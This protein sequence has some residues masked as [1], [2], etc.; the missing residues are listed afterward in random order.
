M[1]KLIIFSAATSLVFLASCIGPTAVRTERIDYSEAIAATGRQ[2]ILL[3]FVRVYCHEQPQFTDI[4]QV[5][6]AS[7]VSGSVGA[8]FNIPQALSTLGGSTGY[9][10]HDYAPMFSLEP[11]MIRQPLHILHSWETLLLLKS[12]GRSM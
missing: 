4:T 9:A 3:N 5:N 1:N 7:Q 8:T 6:N 10:G 2:Q 12:P 11:P